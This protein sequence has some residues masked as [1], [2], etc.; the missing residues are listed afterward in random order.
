[1]HDWASHITGRFA[2]VGRAVDA[3]IVEELAQHAAAA[4]E[5]AR[6]EGL[7]RD[8]AIARVDV[9]V[10]TWVDE[11]GTLKHRPRREAAVVPPSAGTATMAGLLHDVRY[12]LRLAR[13]PA[14]PVHCR[15]RTP[16]P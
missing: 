8:E 7:A 12:A 9:L 15:S 13:R 10:T 5:S 6:A 4:Y 14:I 11:A 16:P 1:M 2:G 3:D